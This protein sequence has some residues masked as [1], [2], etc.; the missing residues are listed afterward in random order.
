[1]DEHSSSA[2]H[3]G[4]LGRAVY[5]QEV[6]SW[7]F[8]RTLA[9]PTVISYTGET[10]T[11]VPSS[12]R[13]P[14]QILSR[15]RRVNRNIIPQ[16]H[17]DLAVAWSSTTTT[18]EEAISRVVTTA[19]DNYDPLVSSTLDVG[20]AVDYRSEESSHRQVPIA[21]AIS[22]ECGNSVFLSRMVEDIEVLKRERLEMRVPSL[23][24]SDTTEWSKGGAPIRQVC[25]ARSIDE[26]ATWMAVRLAESTV[27][28][29]PL[30]HRDPVPMH[31]HGGYP[32]ESNMPLRNTRLDANP[33]S[34]VS[35]SVTGGFAHADV[36]FNPWYQKQF[37]LVDTQ[38]N[39]SVWEIKGRQRRGGRT[40]PVTF[41]KS[42][43]LP[44]LSDY[45]DSPNCPRH[46]GW[47]SIEW[48]GDVWSLL[49]SDRR[50]TT[51]YRMEGEQIRSRAVELGL[52]K[53]SEWVLDVQR[54]PQNPSQ[55]FVLTTSRVLWFDIAT[56]ML[57]EEEDSPPSIQP[58]LAWRHFRDSEDTT[59][60]LCDVLMDRDLY[61]ILYSR[62]TELVQVYS[63]PSPVE[64]ETE[65]VSVPDPVL[66]QMPSPEDNQHYSTLVFREVAHTPGPM[67][68]TG[69]DPDLRLF[70]LFWADQH[71][72]LHE[73]LFTSPRGITDNDDMYSERDVLRIK[74][75]HPGAQRKQQNIDDDEFVVDDWDESVAP[76]GS[77]PQL[78]AH[79]ML[80]DPSLHESRNLVPIYE[81]AAG[82]AA[83][84]VTNE[85]HEG[86]QN[87]TFSQLLENFPNRVIHE[88]VRD[89][90]RGE[91][92]LE[93]NDGSPLINDID[94]NARDLERL[95]STLVPQTADDETQRHFMIL[96]QRFSNLFVGLPTGTREEF[97]NL[98]LLKSYDELV[99]DW[100]SSLSQNIPVRTRIMKEKIVRGIVTDLLLSRLILVSNN[101][102]PLPSG[103]KTQASE[104]ESATSQVEPSSQGT[105]PGLL[106]PMADH[107]PATPQNEA[108]REQPEASVPIY[109]S[110][111]SFTTLDTPRSMP[112]N[113]ATLLSHWQ[114]GS[115]P[116]DYTWTR[117]T[118]MLEEEMSQRTSRASTPKN[119]LRKKRSQSQSQQDMAPAASSQPTPSAVRTVRSWGTQGESEAPQLL[120]SQPTLDEPMT[121]IERGHFGGREASTKAKKKKKRA[122]GF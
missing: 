72:A 2:L 65:P 41:I 63:C 104:E 17:S 92:M 86:P 85:D 80:F 14:E 75:R 26:K 114:P 5:L 25:F 67:S 88:A 39:W 84:G 76:F 90:G 59:L 36:T 122:A 20:H 78:T 45:K 51:I 33:V 68:R 47:A 120:S 82:K 87:K 98:D 3:Y 106:S 28:F 8:S 91:T 18:R 79:R 111:S 60:R 13:A 69:Y 52:S 58:R 56:T 1:M 81:V 112:P 19:T 10:K 116:A 48:I 55:F 119:R 24:G 31:I 103:R 121:Q 29:H 35:I 9:R 4:H 34:E 83:A 57:P 71:L 74:R 73:S 6:Q 94:E 61:L 43:S 46:D 96:P 97:S 16:T 77:R 89:E 11:R 105:T 37:A 118:Q 66:L 49:V 40:L 110:L 95:I 100:L 93:L 32:A 115:D 113:V 117:T 21:I 109:S 64:G 27:I 54:S 62:I 42:G 23:S 38:G 12:R 99:H 107:E 30:Y 53:K 101:P 44:P 7:S 108:P 50:C 15:P 22:G 102:I 70:K